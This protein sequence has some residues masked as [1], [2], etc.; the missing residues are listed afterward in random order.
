MR[1]VVAVLASLMST[2]VLALEVLESVLQV[3]FQ[4]DGTEHVLNDD[5]VPLLPGNACYVWYLRVDARDT[6]LTFVER[7]TLPQAIDWGTLDDDPGG[8]VTFEEGGKVAVSTIALTTDTD[9]W[10]SHGWCVAEGDPVGEHLFEVL[11]DGAEIARFP[12]TVVAP[13]AYSFP[14]AP[15]AGA[16][17][18]LRS[19]NNTW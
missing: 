9:G 11:V 3:T 1:L 16:E 12:F 8:G 14:A 15:Q 10:F 13:E 2:P 18:T 19:A 7:L 6:P 5:V 17:D 4:R